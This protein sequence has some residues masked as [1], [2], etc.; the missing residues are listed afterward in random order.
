[1]ITKH[2]AGTLA[3]SKEPTTR[4]QPES[5]VNHTPRKRGVLVVNDSPLIRSMLDLNLRRHGFD[6]WH[7]ENGREA[8]DNYKPHQELID[9]ILL[10]V[11]MPEWTGPQAFTDIL[12]ISPLVLCCFMSGELGECTEADLIKLGAKQIVLKLLEFNDIGQVIF[13][14]IE[15]RDRNLAAGNIQRKVAVIAVA[16]PCES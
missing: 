14:L 1:M 12:L 2:S 15:L 9:L 6:V 11:Q 3:K 16:L 8:V 10:D 7:A 13:D 4:H 5:P